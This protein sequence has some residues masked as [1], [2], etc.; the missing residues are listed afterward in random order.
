[1]HCLPLSFLVFLVMPQENNREMNADLLPSNAQTTKTSN[2]QRNSA[3]WDKTRPLNF[4]QIYSETKKGRKA[5][6][7][8][9]NSWLERYKIFHE[10]QLK[11]G[12]STRYLIYSC[13]GK[14]FGCAGY[15]NRLGGIASL[16]FLAVLTNRVFLID[17]R[18]PEVLVLERFFLP[19]EIQWNYNSDE[20]KSLP[21]RN[22]YWGKGFPKKLQSEHMTKPSNHYPGFAAWFHSIDFDTYFDQPVERITATWNFVDE[23]WLNPHLAR[24]AKE[25]GLIKPSHKYSAIE[26]IFDVL[27]QMS[28]ELQSKLIQA[29][30][31]LFSNGTGPVIGLHIRM[32]DGAFGRKR[33]LNVHDHKSFFSCAQSV[34]KSLLK[35]NSSIKGSSIKWFL[36]TDDILIKRHAIKNFPGKIRTLNFQPQHIGI[37][38]KQ[39]SPSFEG[40]I[41]V[42][43]D[44]FILADCLFLILSNYSTFG[45]T[46]LGLRYHAPNSYTFGD[47]CGIVS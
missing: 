39:R 20:L 4:S 27:F 42:L 16:L 38:Q 7:T 18:E 30:K 6:Q 5:Y 47:A 1:M 33:P 29:R 45:T 26:C 40:M 9:G 21:S 19:N 35:S 3:L 24:R 43:L 46:A 31:E 22:H 15:G 36:A 8:C 13:K 34:E 2:R 32:G 17:W 28:P 12:Q 10:Q 25:I 41:G 14:G 23:I 11:L 44:H 37:F